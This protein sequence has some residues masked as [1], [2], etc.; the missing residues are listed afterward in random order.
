MRSYGF[1]FTMLITYV[2]MCSLR[3][4]NLAWAEETN[5]PLNFED[6]SIE[7]LINVK[8]SV[9]SN[10][11][12]TINESP[13]IVTLITSDEIAHMGARDLM[14]VLMQVPGF[15]MQSNQY[16]LSMA[17]FRGIPADTG[18]RLILIDGQE[19]NE[20]MFQTAEI[21]RRFPISMI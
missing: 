3:P 13:G 6:M 14:D 10:Q 12:K 16:S 7:Q 21:G 19:M 20:R 5:E 1:L 4:T 17:D 2:A 11:P 18:K 9:A 8:V 15:H